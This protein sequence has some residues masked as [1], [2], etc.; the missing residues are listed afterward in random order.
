MEVE[1]DNAAAHVAPKTGGRLDKVLPV[2]ALFVSF[3]S[4][5]LAWG[6]GEA[7]QD[8]VRQNERLVQANSLPYL[9]IYGSNVTSEGKPRIAFVVANQG[10]GPAEVRTAEV[11]VDGKPQ[12]DLLSFLKACCG[13][14]RPFNST[15]TSTLSGQ[16]I[17]QGERINFIELA[18][19]GA[20]QAAL[21]ALD[22]ARRERIETRLCYCSVFE[23][24]WIA[25]SGDQPRPRKVD[26]CPPVKTP[27]RQ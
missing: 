19:T 22:L 24:C 7:M 13:D 3:L 23:E 25:T 14:P 2:S 21:D 17:R 4:I 5:L 6:N 9:Q 16:M 10:I 18:G 26:Q 8:L 27:Y 11:L 20:N 15:I 1:V 12:P